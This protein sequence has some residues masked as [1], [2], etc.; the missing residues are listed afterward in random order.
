MFKAIFWDNDGVLVETEHLYAKA[1]QQV[2]DRIG[3]EANAIEVYREETMRHGRGVFHVVQRVMD[4]SDEE[5]DGLRRER[6]EAYRAFFAEGVSLKSGVEDVLKK[7]KASEKYKMGIVT[8]CPRRAFDLIHA[9]TGVEQY[10]DFILTRDE[11]ERSK[12][13]PECYLKAV[14]LTGFTPESCVAIEDS[15]RGILAAKSAGIT[16]WGIHSDFPM[17]MDLGQADRVLDDIKSTLTLL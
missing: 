4:L 17:D 12:P 2:F 10:M 16:C 7:L 14:E 3:F 9:K 5:R 8:A 6:D 13:S 15:E 1:I 11:F